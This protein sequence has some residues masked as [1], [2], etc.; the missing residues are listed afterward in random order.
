M[1][2]RLFVQFVTVANA[3]NI[4]E[5]AKR[6]NIAQPALSHAIATLESDLGV[7]LFE[8]H[9]RGVTLTEAGQTLLE[10][11]EFIL[12]EIDSARDAVRE[13]ASNP[14][15]KVSIAL[16]ASVSYVLARPMCERI[17]RDYPLINFHLEE[18]L[19]GNLLQAMRSGS[20]DAMIDFD[21]NVQNEMKSQALLKE[22]LYLVGANLPSE[23]S[24]IE[25]KDLSAFLLH[26]PGREHAMG[27]ALL[28]YQQST[29]IS[30]TL[31]SLKLAVH[32]MLQLIEA[33]LGYSI[34]PWSLIYD[35]VA[36]GDLQA[37][38]IVEPE[39]HR[40]VHLVYPRLR[41]PTAATKLVIDILKQEIKAAHRD[42][43]WRGTLLM[44]DE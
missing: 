14:S 3:E 33:G 20:L 28:N 29:G 42:G 23:K 39:L 22:D 26:A 30:L 9:R 34:S 11:A 1:N 19:T 18:G 24:E 10:R 2:T 44:G 16:P 12:N 40:I 36:K 38:K 27:R 31:A 35:K 37:L 7:K 8:R 4:S 25:F 41:E 21:V 32:P 13:K 6:L 43:R 15:G 17:M 5:A